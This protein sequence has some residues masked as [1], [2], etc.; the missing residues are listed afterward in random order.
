MLTFE[1]TVPN[2][3]PR[4]R[5]DKPANVAPLTGIGAI[6]PAHAGINLYLY[7]VN[8]LACNLPRTRGDKP[9]AHQSSKGSM[10]STPHTRG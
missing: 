10:E 6:Y 5:G 4:T 9:L 1:K 7:L 8:R 3:L 2:H